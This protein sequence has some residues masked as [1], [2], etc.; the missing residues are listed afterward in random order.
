MVVRLKRQGLDK[1]FLGTRRGLERERF[2][3]P[4]SS[5]ENP[6]QLF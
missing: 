2:L 3:E 4:N 6:R 1:G 5:L